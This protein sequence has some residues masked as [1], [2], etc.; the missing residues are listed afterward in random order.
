M[1]SPVRGAATAPGSRGPWVSLLCPGGEAGAVLAK[2]PGKK[3]SLAWGSGLVDHLL[4]SFWGLLA[5]SSFGQLMKTNLSSEVYM[6]TCDFN[7]DTCFL[8]IFR[9]FTVSEVHQL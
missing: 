3:M 8:V 9:G 2:V 5:G 6:C 4:F 7:M 1:P